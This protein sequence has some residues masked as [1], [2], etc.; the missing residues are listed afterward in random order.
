MR[1]KLH[2]IEIY[3]YKRDISCTVNGI[4]LYSKWDKDSSVKFGMQ[5]K[6]KLNRNNIVEAKLYRKMG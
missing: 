4:K 2:F 1:C 3:I 5:N 6:E